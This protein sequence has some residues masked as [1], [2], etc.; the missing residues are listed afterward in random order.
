ML[1]ATYLTASLFMYCQYYIHHSF[2]NQLSSHLSF[3]MYALCTEYNNLCYV[4]SFLLLMSYCYVKIKLFLYPFVLCV[5]T[6]YCYHLDATCN[7]SHTTVNCIVTY[8]S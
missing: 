7:I 6:L 1:I 4:T 2:C 3:H 8:M 5:V